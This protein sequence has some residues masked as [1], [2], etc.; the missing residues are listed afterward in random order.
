M[1]YYSPEHLS[2]WRLYQQYNALSHISDSTSVYGAPGRNL[3]ARFIVLVIH[4]YVTNYPKTEQLKSKHIYYLT[5]SLGQK[6]RHGLA[7]T[8]V[9]SR[10]GIAF[11]VWTGEGCGCWQH[12]VPRGLLHWGLQFLVGCWLEVTLSTLSCEPFHHDSL[13][14]PV[15]QERLLMLAFRDFAVS[16]G[17]WDLD[18]G[19]S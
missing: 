6:F 9:S 12:S 8:E 11:E 3:I 5:V 16:S 1:W 18:L 7:A 19:N 2:H 15:K 17:R 13:W 10:A 4:Y 14:Q